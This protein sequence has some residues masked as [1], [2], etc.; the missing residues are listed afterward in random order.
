MKSPT[1]RITTPQY[2]R[3]HKPAPAGAC[4]VCQC[5]RRVCFCHKKAS[6]RR[7]CFHSSRC[8]NQT[9]ATAAYWQSRYFA[10]FSPFSASG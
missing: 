7:R 6:I 4:Y 3:R 8:C 2:Y 10:A 5:H 9:A 1:S